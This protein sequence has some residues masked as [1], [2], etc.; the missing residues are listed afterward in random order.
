MA[1]SGGMICT[2]EEQVSATISNGTNVCLTKGKYT[3]LGYWLDLP[4]RYSGD[5]LPADLCE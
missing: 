3:A 2:V 5:N 1:D 4:G